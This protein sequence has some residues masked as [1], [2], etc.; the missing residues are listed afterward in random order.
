MSTKSMLEDSGSPSLGSKHQR[1]EPFS[2]PAAAKHHQLHLTLASAVLCVGTLGRQGASP[3]H[4][5]EPR[6]C[7]P[8]LRAHLD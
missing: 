3:Q 8:H 4:L 7:A 2:Y 6:Y 1:N 5:W